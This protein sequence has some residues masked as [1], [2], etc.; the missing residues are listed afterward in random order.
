M[1]TSEHWTSAHL[2]D[3]WRTGGWFG[4]RRHF[5]I[6]AFGVNAWRADSEGD[7][8]ISEHPETSTGHQELYLVLDGYAAFTVDGAAIDA[9]RGTL[10]F[11]RDPDLKR[12]AVARQARTT[13]LAIGAKAGEVFAPSLWEASG[14]AFPFFGTGEYEKAKEILAEAYNEKPVV[15][16]VA[17]NLACAEA[18]LGET[19]AAIEHLLEAIANDPDFAGYAQ[20]DDDFASIRDDPRFPTP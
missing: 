6:E 10:V 17:Y 18:R 8:V 1:T 15:A 3:V 5:G 9:P 19:D 2:E 12:K 13:V 7:D 4:I 14:A 16:G 20:D 11:V